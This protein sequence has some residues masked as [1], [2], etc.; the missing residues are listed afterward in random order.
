MNTIA[1][2]VGRRTRSAET[3]KE[4]SVAAVQTLQSSRLPA[5]LHS[6]HSPVS[7]ESRARPARGSRYSTLKPQIGEKPYGRKLKVFAKLS[8][9]ED[10]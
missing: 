2:A 10:I 4:E 3:R 1:P 9:T 7:R 6:L 5:A 8:V